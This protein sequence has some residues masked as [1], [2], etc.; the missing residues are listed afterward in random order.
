VF[1][2]LLAGL[3]SQAA[4]PACPAAGMSTSNHVDKKLAKNLERK[5]CP[6]TPDSGY[7]V[8]VPICFIFS[9][10]YWSLGHIVPSRSSKEIAAGSSKYFSPAGAEGGWGSDGALPSRRTNGP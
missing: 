5:W 4:L 9:E 2:S 6:L 3:R 8:G 1:Q 7:L 10:R